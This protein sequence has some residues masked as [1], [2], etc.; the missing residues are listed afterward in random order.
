[1]EVGNPY[2]RDVQTG[3]EPE[4]E[5]RQYCRDSRSR[6]KAIRFVAQKASPR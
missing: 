2:Q 5:K 6:E 3:V 1:M 4:Q